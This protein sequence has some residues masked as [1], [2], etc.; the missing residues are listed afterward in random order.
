[1]GER[2]QI[3]RP[4]LSHCGELA[5]GRSGEMECA[6]DIVQGLAFDN[7]LRACINDSDL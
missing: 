3:F 5:I 4:E 2:Y 7:G 6:R 1:M